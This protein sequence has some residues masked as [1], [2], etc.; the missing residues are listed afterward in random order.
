MQAAT[1]LNPPADVALVDVSVLDKAARAEAAIQ[2]AN[3][4][5]GDGYA[6][7]SI[8]T[9]TRIAPVIWIDF[10][11]RLPKLVEADLACYYRQGIDDQGAYRIGQCRRNGCFVQWLERR[12][13]GTW[14]H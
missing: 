7:T 3:T 8:Q 12:R 1:H 6:V 14:K 4:L 9:E 11:R 5:L 13:D 2:A 10:D